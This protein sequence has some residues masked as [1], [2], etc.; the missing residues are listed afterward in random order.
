MR[1]PVSVLCLALAGWTAVAAA[2]TDVPVAVA[3]AAPALDKS[4]RNILKDL[5]LTDAATEAK[6]TAILTAHFPVL[7]AWHKQNDPQLKAL[8]AGFDQ[9]RAAKD[10]AG[11]D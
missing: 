2:H 11:A 1:L 6:V 5:K 7:T 10:K 3:P 8:W 4:T 9:A